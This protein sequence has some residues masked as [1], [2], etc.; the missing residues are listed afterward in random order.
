MDAYHGDVFPYPTYAANA[1]GFAQMV[2]SKWPFFVSKA[3]QGSFDRDTKVVGRIAA[4]AGVSGMNV[5]IYHFMDASPIHT[6]IG[7]FMGIYAQVLASV[8]KGSF[9]RLAVDNEPSTLGLD[10]TPQTDQM[11]SMMA[12]A[13]YVANK[14]LP[15]IYGDASEFFSAMSCGFMTT[16]P[17]WL[18]KYG[19]WATSAQCGPGWTNW[20][21]QQF[22]GDGINTLNLSVPGFAGVQLDMSAFAGS[23][24]EAIKTWVI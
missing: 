17:R 24:A 7:N 13:M 5:S 16:C 11:A 14:R 23:L 21:W 20:Q 12:Q 10:V 3:S 15:L 9:I 8:P 4:A 19:P 22:S 18:A 6:Q 2:A 1:Y